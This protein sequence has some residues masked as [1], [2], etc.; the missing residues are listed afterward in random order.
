MKRFMTEPSVTGS[1]KRD[2]LGLLIAVE[3]EPIGGRD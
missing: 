3:G 1:L 2:R